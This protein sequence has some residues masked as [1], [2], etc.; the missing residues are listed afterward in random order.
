MC[1]D[2]RVRYL[3][4]DLDMLFEYLDLCLCV[5]TCSCAC[6]SNCAVKKI[7]IN[8]SIYFWPINLKNPQILQSYS[9]RRTSPSIDNHEIYKF[10]A[11]TVS[12]KT[13]DVS[14]WTW[15][16]TVLK[17]RNLVLGLVLGFEGQVLGHGVGLAVWVLGLVL[18]LESWVFGLGLGTQV[19]VNNTVCECKI[20]S[21]YVQRLWFVPP[22]LTSK[23]RHTH[24]HTDSILTR[25]YE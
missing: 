13:S 20:T 12:T 25:L 14:A 21:L 11:P 19:L 15:T 8:R 1:L 2:L 18:G 4:L 16:W 3:D 23:Q 7:H 17:Y 6:S 10:Y 5:R 22:W 9:P 24:T